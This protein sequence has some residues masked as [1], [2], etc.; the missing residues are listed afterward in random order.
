VLST[1]YILGYCAGEPGLTT[2]KVSN[3]QLRAFSNCP[4]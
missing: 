3:I 1:S 2:T 4:N